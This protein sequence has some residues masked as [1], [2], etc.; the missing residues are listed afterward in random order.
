MS[1]R[2]EMKASFDPSGDH[3]GDWL[4]FFA[5]VS[6]RVAPLVAS[7]SQIS[8]SYALSSQ[9]DSRT[10]YATRRPSGE[11]SGEPARFNERI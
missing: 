6:W 4:D 3:A 1:L 9:F 2:S 8:V 7:A 5:L 10:V 11:I